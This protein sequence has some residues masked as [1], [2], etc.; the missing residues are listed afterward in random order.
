VLPAGDPVDAGGEA[1]VVGAAHAAASSS[2]VTARTARPP[3]IIAVPCP[4][5]LPLGDISAH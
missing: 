4:V 1:D 2:A 5:E 3:R